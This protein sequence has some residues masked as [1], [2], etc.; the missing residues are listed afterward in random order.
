M[1]RFER[2]EMKDG[3]KAWTVKAEHGRYVPQ[4]NIA[5]LE[6]ANFS[7]FKPNGEE[8]K[9]SAPKA[10]LELAG[11]ALQ[12]AKAEGGV[13][14]IVPGEQ[15]T[16]SAPTADY[17]AQTGEVTATGKVEIATPRA[18]ITGKMLHVDLE[19]EVFTITEGVHTR[20]LPQ[21]EE[22]S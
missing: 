2:S 5:E 11:Q 8:I 13:V 18:S 3:K 9:L 15:L 19:H 4:T 16:V 10:K 7:F 12:T 21:S 17:H 20:L 22:K 1:Q 6:Q 14:L